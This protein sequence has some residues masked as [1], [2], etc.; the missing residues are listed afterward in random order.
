MRPRSRDSEIGRSSAWGL[1]NSAANSRHPRYGRVKH[2]PFSTRRFIIS[3]YLAGE[4][5]PDVSKTSGKASTQYATSRSSV[6][7]RRVPVALEGELSPDVSKTSGKASTQYATSRSSVVLRRVRS[8]PWPAPAT[9]GAN[10]DGSRIHF[11]SEE[12]RVG[13]DWTAGRS[14]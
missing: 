2:W 3:A 11:R 4:L 9:S 10:S 14:P 8:V 6:G 1:P 7:L 13:K 12:R 5:S